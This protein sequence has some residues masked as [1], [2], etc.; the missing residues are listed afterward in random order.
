MFY[1][2]FTFGLEQILIYH[3]QIW[4]VPQQGHRAMP[5]RRRC[6]SHLKLGWK[7]EF[8]V[9]TPAAQHTNQHWVSPASPARPQHQF[10]C[11]LDPTPLGWDLG[12]AGRTVVTHTYPFHLGCKAGLFKKNEKITVIHKWKFQVF[13]TLKKVFSLIRLVFF[14]SCFWFFYDN[15]TIQHTKYK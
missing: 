11:N 2:N 13:K 10:L 6:R 8:H 7:R 4:D 12:S 1:R 9:Q 5:S 3:S 14:K 15:E